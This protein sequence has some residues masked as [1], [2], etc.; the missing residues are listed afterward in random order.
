MSMLQ[1]CIDIC[2]ILRSSFAGRPTV[3]IGGGAPTLGL[4]SYD[5]LGDPH[6]HEYFTRR[7]SNVPRLTG[8]S[9]A[10][11]QINVNIACFNDKE[12]FEKHTYVL[13]IEYLKLI[14]RPAAADHCHH[15]RHINSDN[16][17]RQLV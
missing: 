7:F 11:F 5:A 6:L 9:I 15:H 16:D 10:I 8:V 2:I 12:C 3:D 13:L 17:Q 14:F 1:T 4:P